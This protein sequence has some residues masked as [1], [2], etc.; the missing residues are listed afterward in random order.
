MDGAEGHSLHEGEREGHPRTKRRLLLG[1]MEENL[2][3]AACTTNEVGSPDDSIIDL[4]GDED[5]R[6]RRRRGDESIQEE[7]DRRPSMPTGNNGPR[8]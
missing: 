2:Q 8:P 5:K 1:D 6:R 7:D 4:V 3:S